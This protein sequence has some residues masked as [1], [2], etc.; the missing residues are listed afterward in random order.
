MFIISLI[1]SYKNPK[2]SIIP[3]ESIEISTTP[4]KNIGCAPYKNCSTKLMRKQQD[5]EYLIRVVKLA[6]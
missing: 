4:F 1:R 5:M 2:T 6:K 3:F